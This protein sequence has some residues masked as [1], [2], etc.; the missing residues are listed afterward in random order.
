MQIVWITTRGRRCR[1]RSRLRLAVSKREQ[2]PFSTGVHSAAFFAEIWTQFLEEEEE[3]EAEEEE[4]E[5][6]EASVNV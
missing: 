5:E 4:E 3:E 2:W 6:E 1:R